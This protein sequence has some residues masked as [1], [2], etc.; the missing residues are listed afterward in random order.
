[1]TI[2]DK[3][4]SIRQDTPSMIERTTEFFHL[5]DA[6][7]AEPSPEVVT[8]ESTNPDIF[9][10]HYGIGE[11]PSRFG[12]PRWKLRGRG[13]GTAGEL[14]LNLGGNVRDRRRNHLTQFA[15]MFVNSLYGAI[16]L[17]RTDSIHPAARLPLRFALGAVAGKKRRTI[18]PRLPCS[19]SCV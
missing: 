7:E 9:I 4:G 3:I 15:R 5:V 1:M 14:E 6:I 10:A 2:N 18:L 12:K 16:F 17:S 8:L 13:L 19:F 11:S